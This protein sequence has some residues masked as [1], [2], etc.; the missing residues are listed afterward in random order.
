MMLLNLCPVQSLDIHDATSELG[1]LDR[2]LVLGSDVDMEMET[3]TEGES[4]LGKEAEFKTRYVPAL[5]D[6]WGPRRG[7]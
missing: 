4:K 5:R 7:W 1:Q 3:D 6:F 2:N